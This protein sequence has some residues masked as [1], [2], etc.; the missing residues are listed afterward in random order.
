MSAIIAATVFIAGYAAIASEKVH[1]V[2]VVLLGSAVLLACKVLDA[3]DVFHSERYGI[4]WNVIFL[5]LGMMLIVGAIAR[6]GLFDYLA[7]RVVGLT[8]GRPYALL[9]S[10]VALTAVA[11][12]LVDNVTTVLLVAPMT[13]AITRELRLPAVPFLLAEAFASNIGG[14]A[15]L[16]GDPPN[17]I[18]GSQAGLSYLDFLAN[19][20]PLVLVL[21]LV[22]AALCRV[23]F[24]SA[25]TYDA[26][27]VAKLLRDDPRERITDRRMLRWSLAVLAVVTVAF[28]L[29]SALD[30]DPS[31]IAL[32]G[33]GVLLLANRERPALLAEVEWGT[34]AFFGGL[35]IMVG[36][37]IK[38]GIVGRIANMLA[39][40]IDGRLLLGSILLMVVSAV[41]SAVVDNI[42]YVATMAPVVDAIAAGIPAGT[43]ADP[44]WWSLAIGADLGGN[45][46]PIGASANIVILAIAARHGHHIS[47]G[48]FVRYGMLTVAS[49]IAIS[50]GYVWLRY[51]VLA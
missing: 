51:F 15:T 43:S 1:R 35:F 25:L 45:A 11:S 29:H 34:L 14:T 46:T 33:G 48:R 10:L 17:I 31:V 27:R 16:I 12:A 41:L 26:A 9:V 7:L 47:F 44:L 39:E 21:L 4:D 28:V 38:V 30:Y 37:L 3:H 23:M 5:L 20:A 18:I 24:R 6:T 40:A 22:F 42:P 13:I 36:A 50:I 19:L 2:I 8:G 32:L 49:T